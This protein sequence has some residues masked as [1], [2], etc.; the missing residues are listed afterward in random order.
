MGLVGLKYFHEQGN[1]GIAAFGGSSTMSL[2]TGAR[3]Y[4][5]D[6]VLEIMGLE[7][8]LK[9]KQHISLLNI[10]PWGIPLI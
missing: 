3:Q 10:S 1:D 6:C 4:L 5:V 8:H 9:V 7:W 2:N